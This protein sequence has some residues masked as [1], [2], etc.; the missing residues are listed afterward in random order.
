M[1][2]MTKDKLRSRDW[3]AREGDPEM[4]ALYLERYLNY[5]L[6]IVTEN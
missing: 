1:A 5:G 6:L 4:S 2:K 3:F